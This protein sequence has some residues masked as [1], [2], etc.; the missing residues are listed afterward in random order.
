MDYSGAVTP[1]CGNCKFWSQEEITTEVVGFEGYGECGNPKVN[2]D[3]DF[4]GISEGQC[5]YP[6]LFGRDFGCIHF[7]GKEGIPFTTW[8]IS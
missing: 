4:S 3:V 1:T 5:D 6:N 8:L 2:N 7:R